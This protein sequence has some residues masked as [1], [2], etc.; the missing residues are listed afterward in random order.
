MIKV[1]NVTL[2]YKG[3]TV[4]ENISCEFTPGRI[5]TLLGSSGSGKTSLL[6]VVAQL[7]KSYAGVV[8]CGDG[9]DIKTLSPVQRTAE[10]GLVFQSF[11]LFE[12][13]SVLQ[14]CMG[15]L[16]TVVKQTKKRAQS[17][18]QKQ[19]ERLDV[20]GLQDRLPSQ[21]SQGQRQRVAIARALC[22]SPQA[23]LLDEPTSG[24]DPVNSRRVAAIVRQLAGDGIAIVVATHDMDF[25]RQTL[26]RV[27][28]IKQ[29]KIIEYY[30][31]RDPQGKCTAGS[32]IRSF[33]G[34]DK[35][36]EE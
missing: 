19:L 22:F 32:M 7:V 21:L 9:D 2:T 1:K 33:I 6:S 31:K 15:P 17:I 16:M 34:E 36:E 27:Y 13:M 23:L 10:I 24:L 35:R 25:V 8:L 28:F 4:L 18:A 14:N 12:N 3:N 11:N 29:G 20:L 26:D 30:D 5:T